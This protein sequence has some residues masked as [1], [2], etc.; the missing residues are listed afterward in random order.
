MNGIIGM[1]ELALDTELT[2]EQREYLELVKIVGRLPADGHQRHPRLLQD[3]GRQARPGP[4]S[5]STCATRLD[6]TVE[7]ARR[8]GPTRRGWSWPAT[9]PPTC[10]TRL[11]GDPGRLRQVLVN[12][13]GNAIKFTEQGEVVVRV[14]VE[15]RTDGRGR[16]CTSPSRD[17]GIGIPPDKQRQLF[18]A[19]TQAD[20]STTRKYGGTGLGLAISAR[21]VAADGRPDLGRERGRPGQHVP[22]HG[23]LRPARRAGRRGRRR[24]SRPSCTA[25]PCWSWTTTPPTAASWRRCS[26]TGACGRPSCDG[27]AAALAALERAAAAGRAVRRWC[28]ST[29]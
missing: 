7:H 19:F 21:L 25:C 4:R 27:G 16:A 17:T 18:E 24:P 9:S 8:S 26:P 6:D 15:S 1:T 23:P 5:T 22:L 2:A 14:E 29:P 28:C 12:L 13:V 20:G 11:V 10:P 3:R